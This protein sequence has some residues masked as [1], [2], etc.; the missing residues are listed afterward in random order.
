MILL[1]GSDLKPIR[2]PSEFGSLPKLV[3][4][5][6]FWGSKARLI[7]N[8]PIMGVPELRENHLGASW[9]TKTAKKLWSQQ[10]VMTCSASLRHETSQK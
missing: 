6:T 4:G 5:L 7:P 2:F 10:H 9:N 3:M 8:M 1:I